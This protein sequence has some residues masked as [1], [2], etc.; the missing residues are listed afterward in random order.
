MKSLLKVALLLSLPL[1]F[2]A[3]APQ[4]PVTGTLGSGGVFPLI[5]SPSVVFATDANHTMTYPEMSGSSGVLLITSSV[6]LSAPRNVIAPMVRGFGWFAENLTTGGQSIVIKGSTGTGVTIANGYGQVVWCD[7]TNYITPPNG[8]GGTVLSVSGTAPLSSTGGA[9]PVLSMTQATSSVPGY[10]A[11]AD[12]ST[13]NGK[14]APL[15]YTPA[16]AGANSDITSLSGLT[17]PLPTSEGGTGSGG[18]TGYAYGNGSGAF[19]YSPSIPATAGVITLGGTLTS[20]NVSFGTGAGTSPTLATI[21]GNDATFEITLTTGSVPAAN[22]TILTVTFTASRGHGSYGIFA[23]QYDQYSSV[24]QIP[25][26]NGGSPTSITLTS[27]TTALAAS[28]SYTFSV[29]CP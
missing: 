16:H 24:A 29:F 5:N 22:Q 15:G 6:S 26:S 19:T 25:S 18:G 1:A 23:P 10:L 4:I 17:T 8:S 7:G 3:Q 21:V 27:G 20:A 12:W 2:Y 28:T 11:A 13:F 9:N 14:Q